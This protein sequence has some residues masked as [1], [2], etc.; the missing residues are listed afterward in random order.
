MSQ[1]LATGK[2]ATASNVFQGSAEYGAAKA[3]D[4]NDETRGATDGGTTAAWLEVDLGQP[5]VVGH[6]VIAQAFSGA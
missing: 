1:S 3:F 2:K 5:A 6:A 4:G